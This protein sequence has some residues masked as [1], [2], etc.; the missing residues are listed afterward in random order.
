MNKFS[1]KTKESLG[2]YVYVYSDPDTRE[3]FYVGKGKDNRAFAYLEDISDS[4]KTRRIRELR[5]AG[6]ELIVEILA[7]GPDE[8]TALKVEAVAIDLIGIDNLTNKQHG[9]ESSTFGR[10]EASALNARY[11]HGEFMEYDFVDDVVLIRTNKTYRNGMAPF[12]PYEATRGDWKM[13][14]D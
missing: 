10:I 12:E 3:P 7:H 14:P 6:R 9:H 8:A 11:G 13:R 1:A 5:V 4:E 2:Y